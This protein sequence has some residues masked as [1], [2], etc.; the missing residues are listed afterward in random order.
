[1]VSPPKST[2]D[3]LLFP[4]HIPALPSRKV[5][6]IVNVNA[7]RKRCKHALLPTS[8]PSRLS[9]NVGRKNAWTTLLLD[10]LAAHLGDD[11]TLT[12]VAECTEKADELAVIS[13][14]GSDVV[15]L[16]VGV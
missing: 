12:G 1:M 8:R 3:L 13:G 11:T 4:I 7:G 16:I 5:S 2:P 10:E 6:L 14:E 15:W 9:Q